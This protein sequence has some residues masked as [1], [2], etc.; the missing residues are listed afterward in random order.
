MNVGDKLNRLTILE[1]IPAKH[2]KVVCVCDCG[3]TKTFD[4]YNLKK[5]KTKSCGCLYK[6][7]RGKQGF[8]NYKH[9][10]ANKTVEYATWKSMIRRCNNMNVKDYKDYGGRGI[11]VCDQWLNSYES[12]LSD[13]GRKP[14]PS[15]SI[16]RINVDGDYEP[17]NC[18]WATPYEQRMNQRAMK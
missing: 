6:E 1:I 5:G 7:T 15:H 14:S 11:K 13:M 8:C 17:S 2:K 10:E 3:N 18:R 16:D 12:F 9:G 4:F